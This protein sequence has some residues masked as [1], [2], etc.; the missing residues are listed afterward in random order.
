MLFKCTSSLH[1]LWGSECLLFF[2]VNP[3]Y[4]WSSSYNHHYNL[5]SFSLLKPLLFVWLGCL[6][7]FTTACL[8]TSDRFAP[9][10]GQWSAL[11]VLPLAKTC[12]RD[13]PPSSRDCPQAL[14]PIQPQ[15]VPRE[16][17]SPSAIKSIWPSSCCPPRS[18]NCCRPCCASTTNQPTSLWSRTSHPGPHQAGLSNRDLATTRWFLTTQ[19]IHST[20]VCLH[21]STP[22]LPEGRRSCDNPPQEVESLAGVHTSLQTFKGGIST[23]F[24][25]AVCELSG[26]TTKWWLLKWLCCFP[27]S[28]IL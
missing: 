27:L 22:W 24:K 2:I 1:L 4:L 21:Q 18:T 16:H 7:A 3:F 6:L 14:P 23:S 15:R 26:P 13:T 19:C 10:L 9:G 8:P 11:T 28:P 17:N 25:Y 12:T 5:F 20:W